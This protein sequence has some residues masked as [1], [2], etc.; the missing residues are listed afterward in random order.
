MQNAL[1]PVG[2]TEPSHKTPHAIPSCHVTHL[3]FL[4]FSLRLLHQGSPKGNPSGDPTAALGLHGRGRARAQDEGAWHWRNRGSRPSPVI[5]TPSSVG[6]HG[7]ATNQ[8]RFFTLNV[9][10]R[11]NW[12]LRMAGRLWC[13][14]CWV[15]AGSRHIGV[16][17]KPG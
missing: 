1:S 4:A 3:L 10:N 8:E 9:Q 11:C 5:S 6:R 12:E 2:A 14:F 17:S 7:D 16:Y 13:V 15:V